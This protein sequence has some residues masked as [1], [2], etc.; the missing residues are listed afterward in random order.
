MPIEEAIGI[1]EMIEADLEE[2]LAIEAVSFPSPWTKIM[3]M[4]ELLSPISQNIV[5]RL[6]GE[7]AG[8]IDFWIVRDEVHILHIAVRPDLRRRGIATFI[9]GD[10]IRRAH[11][12]GAFAATLEVRRSNRGAIRF[13]ERFGLR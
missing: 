8:Y 13:Y 7:I 5:A 10:M 2:I 3:F 9:M 1:A 12:R 4:E 6:H 11:G